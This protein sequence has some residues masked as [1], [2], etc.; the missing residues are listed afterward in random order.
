MLLSLPSNSQPLHIH[1]RNDVEKDIVPEQSNDQPM[2]C[3]DTF[4]TLDQ[5]ES[6]K[7]LTFQVIRCNVMFLVSQHRSRRQKD[8]RPEL[9]RQPAAASDDRSVHRHRYQRDNPVNN[10]LHK[11]EINEFVL[12]STWCRC[13]SDSAPAM[14]SATS[15][16]DV[17]SSKW[18]S[19]SWSSLQSVRKRW[20]S[21]ELNSDCLRA[22]AWNKEVII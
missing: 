9:K 19:W 7:Q 1:V 17:K 3:H 15:F 21:W 22:S 13:M 5:S 14:S 16:L 4:Q 6:I 18:R 10:P 20:S 2:T 12:Y 11:L 8:D